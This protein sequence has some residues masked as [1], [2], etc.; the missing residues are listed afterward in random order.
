[1]AAEQAAGGIGGKGI[2]SLVKIQNELLEDDDILNSTRWSDVNKIFDG[3]LKRSPDKMIKYA[4]QFK[5]GPDQIDEK[6]LE[7]INFAG[8]L[9]ILSL[10]FTPTLLNRYI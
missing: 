4:S 5:V 2:M 3:I 7:L 10:Y 1:M 9:F 8:K 6:L